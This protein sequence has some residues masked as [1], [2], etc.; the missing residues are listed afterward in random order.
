[1]SI[2][3]KGYT[4]VELVVVILL[5]GVM[6]SM[7][8]IGNKMIEHIALETSVQ[9][10]TK[11]IEYAKQAAAV[12]GQQYNVFFHENRVLVRKGIEKPIYTIR[13]PKNQRIYVRMGEQMVMFDGDITTKD[14]QTIKIINDNLNRQ[15]RLTVDIA[16]SKIR[17]YYEKYKL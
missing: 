12:S 14:A 6:G 11:G 16:T 4:L 15:A 3:Q 7:M 9:Q 17:V 5:I 8:Q 10:V 2:K 13:L 1:M